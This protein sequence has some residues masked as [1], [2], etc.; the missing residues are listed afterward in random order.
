[1]RHNQVFQMVEKKK[2]EVKQETLD[3]L[4]ALRQTLNSLVPLGKAAWVAAEERFFPRQFDT[5]EHLIRAN[6]VV[7]NLFFLTTGLVRFYYADTKGREFNKSFSG[8]GQVVSSMAS[9]AEGMPSPFSVQALAPTTCLTLHY[10]GFLDLAI[11]YPEWS[12][13]RLII[14][15]RLVIKREQR[16]ADLL[17]LSAKERYKKFLAEHPTLADTVPNYHIASYLEITEVALSRIRRQLGLTK[18]NAPHV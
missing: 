17:L 4:E 11:H 10:S 15:K 3:T 12:A 7:T 9:L 2:N 18:V 1:M 5:G 13:L 6:D 16:E 14:L 8:A